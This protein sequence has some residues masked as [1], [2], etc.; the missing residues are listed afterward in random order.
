MI[1]TVF[2]SCGNRKMQNSEKKYLYYD[3]GSIRKEIHLKSGIADG[4]ATFFGDDGS[5]DAL[6]YFKNGKAEGKWVRYYQSNVVSV[7]ETYKLGMR[8]GPFYLF[9]PSGYLQTIAHFHNDSLCRDMLFYYDYSDMPSQYYPKVESNG[10][11]YLEIKYDTLG[12]QIFLKKHENKPV[13]ELH[14][15]L[16]KINAE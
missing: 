4:L 16:D 2:A 11:S 6:G 15:S 8:E 9:F 3:N 12:K 5:I 10:Q 13:D 14:I 7:V 1:L